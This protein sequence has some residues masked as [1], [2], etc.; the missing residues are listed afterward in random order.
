MILMLGKRSVAAFN[1]I[2]MIKRTKMHCRALKLS[3]SNNN[4]LNIDGLL[5]NVLKRA[6]NTLETKNEFLDEI[7]VLCSLLIIILL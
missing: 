5:G 7:D 4:S 1:P 3:S 6:V 2:I